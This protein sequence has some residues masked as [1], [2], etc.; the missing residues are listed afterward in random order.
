MKCQISDEQL[1]L[2][3]QNSCI[4]CNY[5]WGDY[6]QIGMRGAGKGLEMGDGKEHLFRKSSQRKV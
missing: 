2:Y 5:R 3:F 4:Y 1:V 6:L